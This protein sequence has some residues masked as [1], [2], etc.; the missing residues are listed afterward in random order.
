MLGLRRL[1]RTPFV[2][3][4]AARSFAVK[5]SRTFSR[6]YDS[7]VD[8]RLSLPGGEPKAGNSS[9]AYTWPR[10]YPDF[11]LCW[12]EPASMAERVMNGEAAPGFGG[13][14]GS[15]HFHL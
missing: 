8:S 7:S 10:E 13:R 14:F 6:G 1:K 2:S 11:D 12:V 3:E 9:R 15:K 5:T 4:L